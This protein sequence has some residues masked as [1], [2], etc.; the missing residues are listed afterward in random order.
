MQGLIKKN[1]KLFCKRPELHVNTCADKRRPSGRSLSAMS[2]TGHLNI[3]M[4]II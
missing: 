3:L 1:Y 4:I 2:E